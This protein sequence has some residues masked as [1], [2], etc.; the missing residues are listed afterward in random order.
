MPCLLTKVI[1]RALAPTNLDRRFFFG[2]DVPVVGRNP[3][4]GKVDRTSDLIR[5]LLSDQFVYNCEPKF[6]SSSSTARS[7]DISIYDALFRKNIRKRFRN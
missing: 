6:D 5:L 2:D 7:D 4:S 1:H 3:L